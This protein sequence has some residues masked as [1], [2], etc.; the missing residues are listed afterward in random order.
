MTIFGSRHFFHL[1][2]NWTP[3]GH[4]LRGVNF[5]RNSKLGFR[6][7]KLFLTRLRTPNLQ[8]PYFEF[9]WGKNKV[10]REGIFSRIS[11]FTYKGST[12]EN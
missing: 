3:F 11:N 12:K 10:P 1:D 4:C 6:N 7:L 2:I 8:Y 9:G 5:I